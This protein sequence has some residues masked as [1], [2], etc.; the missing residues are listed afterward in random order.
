ML[1]EYNPGMTITIFSASAEQQ[2]VAL[3]LLFAR[4]PVD[5]QPSRLEETLR[6]VK[7]GSL[8]LDGLLLAEEHGQPVGAA[9]TMLQ[10]DSVT[11]VWPPTISC[12]TS[13]VAAVENGLMTRIC[14]VMDAS[15]T[16][17]GQSLIA[18][19]DAAEADLLQQHGFEHAADMFFLARPLANDEPWEDWTE[20]D[21]DHELF[22]EATAD[23]FAAT[24][25]RTYEGSLDCPVL[26]GFRSGAEAMASHRL[27]GCFDPAGWRLYRMGDQV[28]GLLL[29]NEHP[30]QDAIELVY[31]GIVPEFRGRGLGRRL[32]R[33]GLQAASYTG[34]AVIF[35]AVDCGNTYANT[36][37]DEQGFAELARRKV[38]VRR[39]AGLARK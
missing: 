7:R 28:V 16:K 10:S 27:S 18:P 36:L 17:L 32:L 5:E 24:I 21:L 37:Y 39:S 29:M 19:E 26:N 3:R 23:R 15:E 33:D 8:N 9:L 31:F 22:T 38:M 6:S 30:E 4:F 1:D 34:C 13:D 2:I 14:Q 25:E 11:L 35:L 12:Q 20:Q